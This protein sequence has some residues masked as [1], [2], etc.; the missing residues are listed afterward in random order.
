[1]IG[2]L[3]N[4]RR[5]R[6]PVGAFPVGLPGP[7]EGPFAAALVDLPVAVAVFQFEVKRFI[8]L[9]LYICETIK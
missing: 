9:L 7:A 4:L 6:T 5:G 3:T 1:M 8:S 2:I